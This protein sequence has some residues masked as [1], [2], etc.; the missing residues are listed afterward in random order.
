MR[1]G[2]LFDGKNG[3]AGVAIENVK[4][5]GLVAL[6]DDG[7]IFAIKAQSGEQGRGGAVKIPQIVMHE[8]KAPYELAGFATQSDDGVGPFIVAGAKA[9]VIVGARAACGHEKKV[10]RRVHGHNGPGVASA[11]S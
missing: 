1:H 9:A 5:A 3:L 10:A 4:Q 7:D 11:A 2:A 6:D 8:L